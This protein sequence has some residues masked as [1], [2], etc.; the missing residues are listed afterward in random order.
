M[1]AG[2][3]HPPYAQIADGLVALAQAEP[4]WA[5]A[6]DYGLTP[7]GRPLRALRIEDPRRPASHKRPAVLI[8]GTTHGDEYLHIEDRLAAWFLDH[9]EGRGGTAEFFA[10]GG[11][12]LIVPIVNPDAFAANQRDNSHKV[13][14]NRDFAQPQQHV[15]GFE[16]P[17]SR[18]LA[19]W[20]AA[21]LSSQDLDLRM[22]LDYHCCAG[23]LLLPRSY[24]QAA[25]TPTE[26]ALFAKISRLVPQEIDSTYRYGSS[27]KIL[28]YDAVGTS[29]DY[30][31]ETYGS[32]SFTFEGRQNSEASRFAQHAQWWDQVLPL[33]VVE[34]SVLAQSQASADN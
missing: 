11:V 15:A 13:D 4:G 32:L 10:A 34:P 1:A 26:A 21:E 33:L 29:K 18:L 27:D 3:A 16:E 19:R 6:M 9:R 5:T 22:T 20:L 14:L 23:A 25:V 7:E 2:T 30:Y 28:G 31:R 12:L 17:E 24:N 8:T